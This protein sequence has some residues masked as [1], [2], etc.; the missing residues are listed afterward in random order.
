MSSVELYSFLRF[1]QVR[2]VISIGADPAEPLAAN[3][4]IGLAPNTGRMNYEYQSEGGGR[5]EELVA[6]RDMLDTCRV[7]I[8]TWYTRSVE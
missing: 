8:Y 5:G 4:A 3:Q 6:L 2:P 1:P 7:S